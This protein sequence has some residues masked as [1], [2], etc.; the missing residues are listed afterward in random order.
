[1]YTGKMFIQNLCINLISCA[2]KASQVEGRLDPSTMYDMEHS[3]LKKVPCA[4]CN[5]FKPTRREGE[6]STSEGRER[7]GRQHHPRGTKKG[8]HHHSK[9]RRD[10]SSITKKEE[11]AAPRKGRKQHHTKEEWDSRA[12]QCT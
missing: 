12:G 10:E 5:V 6:G 11:K 7:K 2:S 8:K 3:T 4:S 1:M 9:R